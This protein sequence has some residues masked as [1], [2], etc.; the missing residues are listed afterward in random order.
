MRR[1][2]YAGRR[3]A[4]ATL[5]CSPDHQQLYVRRVRTRPNITNT[6][7]NPA[8]DEEKEYEIRTNVEVLR[9]SLLPFPPYD[10]FLKLC[11]SA[12]TNGYP[13]GLLCS[14]SSAVKTIP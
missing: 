3:A 2:L 12:G 6:R 14:G 11:I 13:P 9:A 8:T 7:K 1:K 4:T 10:L 5:D